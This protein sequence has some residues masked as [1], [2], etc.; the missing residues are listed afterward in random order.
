MKISKSMIKKKNLR[1]IP[2]LPDRLRKKEQTVWPG[3][4][5]KF[6]PKIII[7]NNSNLPE[8]LYQREFFASA[9]VPFITLPQQ[10]NFV[11]FLTLRPNLQS[12][13]AKSDTSSR[14][15]ANVAQEYPTILR[16]VTSWRSVLLMRQKQGLKIKC[17]KE[18]DE[19]KIKMERDS[20]SAQGRRF[21]NQKSGPNA[22][23]WELAATS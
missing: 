18:T 17:A 1:L 3:H 12:S 20:L 7:S 11:L 16:W 6:T 8:P 14:D 13:I 9:N 4:G 2:Q 10:F 5:T 19:R 21:R 15:R 23:N 22:N